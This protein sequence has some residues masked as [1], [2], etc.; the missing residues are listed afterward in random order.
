MEAGRAYEPARLASQLGMRTSA[1]RAWLEHW[2]A[3]GALKQDMFQNTDGRKRSCFFM[4]SGEM[5]LCPR[6]EARRIVD[7][8]GQDLL[9]A[10]KPGVGYRVREVAAR[11]V[12]PLHRA[13]TLLSV[14][15][16]EGRVIKKTTSGAHRRHDLYYVSGTEPDA[17]VQVEA[18]QASAPAPAAARMA[19]PL[20]GRPAYDA[21]YA[22]TLWLLRDVCNASR[23]RS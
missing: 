9:D 15:I 10:M 13:T 4:A 8:G 3:V 20:F 18:V 21:E 16:R 14:L 12:L 7:A 17:V 22:R 11:H 19:E 23:G 6:D 2:V 1:V 5:P